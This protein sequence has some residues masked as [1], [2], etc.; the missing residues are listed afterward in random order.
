MSEVQDPSLRVHVSLF[1]GFSCQ[2]YYE[3]VMKN[4]Q[5]YGLLMDLLN[6]RI[7]LSSFL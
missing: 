1:R 7:P 3:V 5:N 2:M 6:G 4:L